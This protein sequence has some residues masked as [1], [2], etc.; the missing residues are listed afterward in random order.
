MGDLIDARHL[1]A[2]TD[3]MSKKHLALYLERTPRWVELRMHEGLPYWR[4]G[5]RVW[6]SRKDVDDWLRGT[7][8]V[9]E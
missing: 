6:F 7:S 4:E 1:F 2:G 9:A 5:R 8:A 3:R